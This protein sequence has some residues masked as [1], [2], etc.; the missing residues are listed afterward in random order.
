MR[1]SSPRA[2]VVAASPAASTVQ[3]ASCA[4]ALIGAANLL[5]TDLERGV[6]IDA[7]ALRT[8]MIA[9]FGASDAEGAWDWKSAYEACEAAQIL[10]LRKF[11]P[12]MHER[13]ASPSRFLA[14]LTKLAALLP[15]HTRRS[16]ESQ[17]LQQFSTP[18]G[19]GFVASM[20]AAITPTDL[21]LEPSA[22]TGLLAIHAELAGG[23]LVV[24]EIADTRADLLDRLFPAVS[25]TRYD[26]AHIHDHLDATVRPTV[27]LM[28]PPFSAAAH[29]DGRVADAALRHLASALARLA[30]GGRLVAITGASLSPDNPS[31][32]DAFIRLQHRG[33]I[34]F[35]AA[36]DGR[37]Y[38]RHGTSVETRLTVID[39][40]PADDAAAFPASP[41]TASDTAMLLDW[42]MRLVPARPAVKLLP[43]NARATTPIVARPAAAHPRH[44]ANSPSRSAAAVVEPAAVELAYEP[45]DWAPAESGRITEA[46]YEGYALQ[47]IRIPGS[48]AHP[49]RLVQSAAMASVAPP[50][51]SYRPHLPA[52][53]VAEGLLSDAQLESVI[54]AGEAHAGYLA[55]SWIV[56]ETFDIVSAAPDPGSSPGQANA[57]TAVRF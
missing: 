38:A 30:E 45:V 17:A 7:R 27:V 34:V 15:S 31:W 29:V 4:D 54:Y 22:G 52:A 20:A 50:K 14:M 19:L 5:L 33:R 11:G 46:L 35:S 39:H 18:I 13:A 36:V 51:P 32:R 23:G 24:N 2:A 53:V 57:E 1:S 49:T 9:S 26:A 3:P 10:F 56:D 37:A 25:V 8:A 42:V 40:V 21:V 47:S 6:V 43:T 41:G 16:E 44:N 12:A 55:G 48:T 28:N